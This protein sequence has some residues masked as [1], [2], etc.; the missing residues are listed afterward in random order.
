M[1][2]PTLLVHLNRTD[3]I[4]GARA[5]LR[6]RAR[7]R[8]TPEAT[9]AMCVEWLRDALES[10]MMFGQDRYGI[11]R[12]EMPSRRSAVEDAARASLEYTLARAAH[13]VEGFELV[14]LE[15]DD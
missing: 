4:T 14:S 6:A 8:T 11:L 2:A 1:T 12:V 15:A 10:A 7:L 13:R 5:P 3:A 9:D